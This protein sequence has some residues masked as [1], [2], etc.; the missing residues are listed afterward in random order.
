MPIYSPQSTETSNK[1]WNPTRIP[2]VLWSW[3][4]FVIASSHNTVITHYNCLISSCWS[5]PV[6]TKTELSK[7][8][9]QKTASVKSISSNPIASHYHVII[10]LPFNVT[11]LK[12]YMILLPCDSKRDPWKF[13]LPGSKFVGNECKG[14]SFSMY[15]KRTYDI[16]QAQPR[17]NIY[18]VSLLGVKNHSVFSFLSLQGKLTNNISVTTHE[19]NQFW[20]VNAAYYGLQT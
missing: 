10:S 1:R 7:S 17:R 14:T 13:C 6:S 5:L 15:P 9:F 11:I 4:S 3:P 16:R 20:N 2:K 8:R 12:S 18:Q 19:E